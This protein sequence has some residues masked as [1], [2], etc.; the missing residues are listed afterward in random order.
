MGEAGGLTLT[1][2][3]QTKLTGVWGQGVGGLLSLHTCFL[4]TPGNFRKPWPVCVSLHW[5]EAALGQKEPALGPR[6][7]WARRTG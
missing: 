1:E 2:S 7:R 4:L 5:R 6:Q 3:S